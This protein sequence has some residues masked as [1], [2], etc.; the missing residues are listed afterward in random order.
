MARRWKMDKVMLTCLKGPIRI[1]FPCHLPRLT[2]IATANVHARKFYDRIGYVR[3]CKAAQPH[4]VNDEFVAVSN[5]TRP[6]LI[7][8]PKVETQK[9]R[10][11]ATTRFSVSL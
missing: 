11:T 3:E 7:M 9:T 5:W 10:K 8:Y 4:M 6:L 1:D 2:S